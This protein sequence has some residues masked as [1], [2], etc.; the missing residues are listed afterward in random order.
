MMRLQDKEFAGLFEQFM[1]EG[2]GE[3]QVG[4]ASGC[5]TSRCG[6]GKGEGHG[7]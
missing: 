6:Q 5:R 1:A 3:G 2:A 7:R 4:G